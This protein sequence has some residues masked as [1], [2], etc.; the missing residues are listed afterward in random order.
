MD[1]WSRPKRTYC[2][3]NELYNTVKAT[4]PSVIAI[5]SAAV[6]HRSSCE[7]LIKI[8]KIDISIS[9]RSHLDL[10]L[11]L[12]VVSVMQVSP[13]DWGVWLARRCMLHGIILYY[14]CITYSNDFSGLPWSRG[15]GLSSTFPDMSRHMQILIKPPRNRQSCRK[16]I[17]LMQFETYHR[18]SLSVLK[19]SWV[20][21]AA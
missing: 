10:L 11:S 13:T 7:W 3:V 16:A 21:L 1:A 4:P 9:I 17:S 8:T 18:S 12:W 2:I 20:S 5:A 19:Q 14:Q 6:P 15:P